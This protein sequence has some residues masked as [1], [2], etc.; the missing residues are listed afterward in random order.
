MHGQDDS[1]DQPQDEPIGDV[2]TRLVESGKSYAQAEINRQK[3]RASEI[4]LEFCIISALIAVAAF[5]TL[6]SMVALIIGIIIALT[7]VM[8][9][10]GATSV[11]V[12]GVLVFAFLLLLLA[13]SRFRRL[14]GEDRP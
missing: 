8:G 3:I 11:V 14:S 9:A 1:I 4:G 12:G 6:A 7:P 5:L 13:R 2:L 10:L